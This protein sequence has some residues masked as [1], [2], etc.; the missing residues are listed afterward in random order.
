MAM[1][2]PSNRRCFPTNT[3]RQPFLPLGKY[4][5]ACKQPHYEKAGKRTIAEADKSEV[6]VELKL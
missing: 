1:F 5:L 3:L 2:D 4:G 6:S